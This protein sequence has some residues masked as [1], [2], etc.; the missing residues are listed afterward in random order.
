ME[1][2]QEGFS[3]CLGVALTMLRKFERTGIITLDSFLLLRMVSSELDFKFDMPYSTND[4]VKEK[5]TPR[6]RRTQK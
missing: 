2:T 3:E 4:S 1:L 6:Q 5:I